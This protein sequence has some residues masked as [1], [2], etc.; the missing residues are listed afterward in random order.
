MTLPRWRA[1]LLPLLRADRITAPTTR[2]DPPMP[3][4]RR[5]NRTPAPPPRGDPPI[6]PLGPRPP[7][8]AGLAGIAGLSPPEMFRLRARGN[9]PRRDTAVIL[10]FQEGGASQFETYAPKPDAP[11]EMR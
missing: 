3:H 9:A 10:V 4:L 2:G 5:P 8:R 7:P 11:A 1:G 6:P